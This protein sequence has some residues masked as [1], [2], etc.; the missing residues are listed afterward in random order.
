MKIKEVLYK[1]PEMTEERL[2]KFI[3]KYKIFISP[4]TIK[5][6]REIHKFTDNDEIPQI[7]LNEWD[8]IQEKKSYLSKSQRDQI[9]A[10]VSISLARMSE[11]EKLEDEEN[12]G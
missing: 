8:L 7:I 3:K 1:T 12:N 11:G 4:Y 6:L 10:L 2:L 9:L 5:R